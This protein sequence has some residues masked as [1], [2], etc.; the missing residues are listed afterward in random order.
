MKR[1]LFL[2]ALLFSM[3]F[4]SYGLQRCDPGFVRCRGG[5]DCIP[6]RDCGVGP[7][8]PGLVVPIDNHLSLLIAA[9]LSLGIYFFASAGK[10]TSESK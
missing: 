9:G 10:K 8:P 6:A 7:P 5:A 4:S 3:S 1:I 2:F